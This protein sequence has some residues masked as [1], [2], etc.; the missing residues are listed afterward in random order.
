MSDTTLQLQD[1]ISNDNSITN[2]PIT[3]GGYKNTGNIFNV[4]SASD[5]INKIS[6]ESNSRASIVIIKEKENDKA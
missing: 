4:Y 3:R 6:L 5:F 1:R 2:D